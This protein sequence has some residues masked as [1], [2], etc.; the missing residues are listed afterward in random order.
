[1][2]VI[3]SEIHNHIEIVLKKTLFVLLLSCLLEKSA[4]TIF[5]W[6]HDWISPSN[7][8]LV[9][10]ATCFWL[11]PKVSAYTLWPAKRPRPAEDRWDACLRVCDW[12]SH[13]DIALKVTGDFP[14]KVCSVVMWSNVIQVILLHRSVGY[15]VECDTF[16]CLNKRPLCYIF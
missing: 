14:L 12:G 11:V 16:Q 9:A 8:V 13:P 5:I 1:M 2:Y 3:S 4:I 10:K 6:T 7:I 15:F